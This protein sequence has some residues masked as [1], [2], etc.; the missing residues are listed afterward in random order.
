LSATIPH[1]VIVIA[2]VTGIVI[3][4][5]LAIGG[6]ISTAIILVIGSATG[7]AV[8][9]VI[10]APGGI[11]ASPVCAGYHISNN[12]RPNQGHSV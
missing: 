12:S 4:S 1:L 8:V 5:M 11:S 3:V 9:R 10:L 7:T 6:L 2:G